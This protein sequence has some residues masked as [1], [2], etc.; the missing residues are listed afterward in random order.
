M[1]TRVLSVPAGIDFMGALAQ[2]LVGDRLGL[3]TGIR[4]D[5]FGLARATVY[6]P[7]RRAT[8]GFADAML[9]A[10]GGDAVLLPRIRAIGAEPDEADQVVVIGAGLEAGEVVPPIASLER[11][12]VL[13]ELVRRW[14]E[15][16]GAARGGTGEAGTGSRM[17]PARAARLAGELARLMDMV[18]TEGAD[19]SRL[20]ELV[21]EAYSEHWRLTLE[22]LSI[23]TAWWPEYLRSRNLVTPA[24]RRNMVLRS[25]AARLRERADE[26]PV[27]VA[28]VTG[29]VPASSDLMRAVAELENCAVI[30]PGVDFAMSDDEWRLVR[31]AHPEHPQHGLARLLESLGVERSEVATLDAQG[32]VVLDG[33]A[34]QPVCGGPRRTLLGEA[35]RPAPATAGWAE[36]ARNRE[37][38]ELLA[39]GLEGL[40]LVEAENSDEEAAVI[41]LV[42]RG[43]LEE[44]GRTGALVTPDRLLARR[45]AIKLEAIGI[46]IDDSAGRPFAKTV[47]GVFL[48]LVIETAA[49]RFSPAVLMALLKH[50]LTRL[51]LAPGELRRRAR[52]LEI[53]VFRQPTFGDGLTALA[54][55]LDALEAAVRGDGIE[56]AGRISAEDWADVR[57]LHGRIV[58]A[59]SD[60]DRAMIAGEELTTSGLVRLHVEAAERIAAAGREADEGEE[61]ADGGAEQ[62]AGMSGG[63]GQE[64]R[65]KNE[66]HA[67]SNEAEAAFEAAGVLGTGEEH[68]DSLLWAGEAGA[69]GREMIAELISPTGPDPM[70]APGDYSELYRALVAGVAVRAAGPVHPRLSIWGPYEARMQQPDVI[71]LG[72]LNEGVWPAAAEPDPWLSRPMRKTLGLPAPEQAI[73]FSAHD[74]VQLAAARRVILTRARKMDGVPGVPSRWLLRLDALLAGHGLTGRLREGEGALWLQWARQLAQPAAHA[75]RPAPAPRP[76]LAA[77]PRRLSATAIGRWVANPYAIYAQYILSLKPLDPLGMEPDVRLRGVILHHAM[78]RFAAEWPRE[79]PDDI[80]ARIGV[81]IETTMRE[82]AAHPRIGAFWGPRF[83]RFAE[84]FA[85]SEADRRDGVERVVSE[86]D[87][88]FELAAPG[89][90]FLLTARADRI[91]IRSD[92][93]IVIYDFK[94]GTGP[95]SRQV[96]DLVQPQLALEALIAHRDGFEG[97]A[98]RRVQ[99]LVHI[100]ASGGEP[101]GAEL[102]VTARDRK[103]EE[104]AADLAEEASSQLQSLVARFDDENTPYV[105]RRARA[106]EASYRYDP[107]AHLARIKEW[108]VAA[109]DGETEDA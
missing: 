71:V 10:A 20:A 26:G 108:S 77:R 33:P 66:R 101:A 7:T 32:C 59:F 83:R 56:R 22:F 48:D 36:G 78:H 30:L 12:L 97:I 4:E 65:E 25:E 73:G 96:L 75:P 76:P 23:V 41:A 38:G 89:G 19:L 86:V 42:L 106:F 62:G 35:M 39:A 104:L 88:A 40:S 13:L 6:L 93:G 109:D 58:G 27:I 91:D 85:A 68:G 55:R 44:P 81:E 18:E 31:E 17:T 21:P 2:G 99:R 43:V 67:A 84:W 52:L 74:F 57:D 3:G 50:P 16:T 95:S 24:E 63:E 47:P 102:P 98:G 8:R 64:G 61:A 87:G 46:R 5:P 37:Q 45:V 105:A 90:A 29:S 9:R 54:R 1:R 70:L 53:A 94:T 60:L 69:T 107:Y 34:G 80:A 49:S 72:G 82:M 92:G 51:G 100:S 11:R 103:D 79:L 14:G 28:G 15:T